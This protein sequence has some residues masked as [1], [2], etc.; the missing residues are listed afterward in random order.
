MEPASRGPTAKGAT[1]SPLIIQISCTDPIEIEAVMDH[2]NFRMDKLLPGAFRGAAALLRLNPL[3]VAEIHTNCTVAQRLRCPAHSRTLLI[4][5]RGSGATYVGGLSLRHPDFILLEHGTMLDIVCQ[6]SGSLICISLSGPADASFV[7]SAGQPLPAATSGARLLSWP[8]VALNELPD[9][10]DKATV[11]LVCRSTPE[12]EALTG[13]LLARELLMQLSVAMANAVPT[14]A[15]RLRATRRRVAVER[16]RGFIRNNLTESL[17]LAD[18][19]RHA[20]VQERSLEYGFREVVG[21]RP[22]AYIKMLRLAEVHRQLLADSVTARSISEVALDTGF[23]HLGQFAYDYKALFMESPSD[24]LKRACFL[25]R[26]RDP[27]VGGAASRAAAKRS[28]TCL[29]PPFTSAERDF[30]KYLA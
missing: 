4:P 8:G 27:T 18:L 12:Q 20:H 19:C 2:W 1:T 30:R 15:S 6:G 7:A 14:D 24:T 10:I 22:M 23:C 16:A 5:G 26:S 3:L 11:A 17:R 25:R 21:L 28:R 29:D 13:A 9:W